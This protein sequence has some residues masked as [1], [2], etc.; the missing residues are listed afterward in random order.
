[1]QIQY[2]L[3]ALGHLQILDVICVCWNQTLQILKDDHL[4]RVWYVVS[5]QP[6]GT[7]NISG[8]GTE[9]RTLY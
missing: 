6:L 8:R 3:Q 9:K 5:G 1:M 4:G 2:F 7:R